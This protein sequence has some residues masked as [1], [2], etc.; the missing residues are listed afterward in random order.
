MNKITILVK[1]NVLSNTFLVKSSQQT[2]CFKVYF[3]MKF[4]CQKD[5]IDLTVLVAWV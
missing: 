2:Y 5:R 4:S 3:G 1:F